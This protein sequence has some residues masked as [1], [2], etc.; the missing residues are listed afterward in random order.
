MVYKGQV[1]S[2][3]PARYWTWCFFQGTS[4]QVDGTPENKDI[5]K[6]CGRTLQGTY[7]VGA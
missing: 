3:F 1:I 5:D 7:L 2:S 6:A 4:Q